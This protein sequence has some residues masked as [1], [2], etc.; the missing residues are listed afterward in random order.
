MPNDIEIIV[1]GQNKAGPALSQVGRQLST[2]TRG[3]ERASAALDLLALA[4]EIAERQLSDLQAAVELLD[5]TPAR[6][7]AEAIGDVGR[8]AQRS[9][10]ATLDL[11]MAAAAVD[12]LETEARQAARA[13]DSI[14]DAA[15]RARPAVDSIG[16]GG[17]PAAGIA[18]QLADL[19]SG[20]KHGLQSSLGDIPGQLVST[21]SSA[22]PAGYA[23][24]V[25]VGVAAGTGLAAG[26]AAAMLGGVA[27]AGIAAGV[28]A[29]ATD[30]RVSMAA[31]QV[32]E[33]ILYQLRE[34]GEPFAD[35]VI[36]ALNRI[37]SV[38][39]NIGLDEA[40]APLASTITPLVDSIV[41]MVQ[42]AMPGIR[43]MIA[44][45]VPVVEAIAAELPALGDSIG[46]FADSMAD[47][48]PGAAQFFG[49]IMSAAGFLIEV[50]GELIQV[51][52][53]VYDKIGGLGTLVAASF[54]PIGMMIKPVVDIFDA[55]FGSEREGKITK[56]ADVSSESFGAIADSAGAAAEELDTL[57]EVFD[58]ISGKEITL[59]ETQ[60]AFQEALDKAT[61]SLADHGA[62]LDI[63]T[64]AGR[65]NS[66]ALL[67]I[68]KASQELAQ[69]TYNQTYAT[70]G[71]TAAA[72]AAAAQWESGR[73]Q[74]MQVAQQMGMT[75]AQAQ[76]YADRV[77]RIPTDWRTR[78]SVDT[79]AA[80][81]ALAR[82]RSAIASLPSVNTGELWNYYGQV[83]GARAAGGPVRAGEAY[84]VGENRP[85][86]FIPTQD[87]MILP[88]VPSRSA[89]TAWTSSGG[90]Y[91][92]TAAVVNITVTTLDPR[93]AADSVMSALQEWERSNGT[94]WRT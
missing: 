44:A 35:P 28:A 70:Q 51:L 49:D 1:T 34:I 90:G 69:A 48:G 74:L 52:S 57:S 24:M 73:Q 45:S 30:G 25:A 27:A 60:I 63:D 4:A 84:I 19:A 50:F 5:P 10:A 12:Q 8:Q 56:L 65:S 79:S 78:V 3:A 91:Q 87:G 55:L 2:I 47:A 20:A 59:T 14:G 61:K 21:L 17:S 7:T 31:G 62:T 6:R 13:V 36:R 37:K 54:G 72:Q 46:E 68:V 83:S 88:E 16:R 82:V 64:A 92:P 9:T 42:Q 22:G 66:E 32:R 53:W 26:I 33:T 89:G 18:E 29:A 41:S 58:R 11:G 76:A 93:A 39:R 80:E 71:E 94:G 85:E 40:I 75:A 43:S 86:L 77:M 81:A 15:E 38:I 67:N 23:A